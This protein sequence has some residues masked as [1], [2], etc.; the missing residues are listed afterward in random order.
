MSSP[1]PTR[2]LH[3]PACYNVRD[4]GGL[5]TAAGCVTRWRVIIRLDIPARLTDAGQQALL[6]YG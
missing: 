2:T 3:W 5:P 4:L 1:L 6:D